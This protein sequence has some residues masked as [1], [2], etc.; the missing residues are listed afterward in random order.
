[1]ELALSGTA[2][3]GLTTNLQFLAAV[4]KNAAFQAGGV[5][6]GFID[7][8]M[9]SLIPPIAPP[10]AEDLALAAVTALMRRQPPPSVGNDARSPWGLGNAWRSNQENW[11]PVTFTVDGQKY[12]VLLQMLAGGYRLRVKDGDEDGD[13]DGGEDGD[14]DFTIEAGLAPDGMLL[15]LID[16][17][18][19]RCHTALWD[20][21]ISLMRDGKCT[22]FRLIEEA[23]DDEEDA[24]GPGAVIAP[25][26]GRIIELLSEDGTAVQAGAPL[27]I[28]E[29]MK[30]EYTLTAPRHGTVDGIRIKAGDQVIDGQLL[31]TV[32]QAD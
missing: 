25:M 26:P 31:L 21:T 17:E 9:T 8:H 24:E 6:T 32:S 16:G 30:M 18:E 22:N 10:S 3:A 14:E 12:H 13:E 20:H 11:D 1:M 28:M 23:G 29:A 19:T 27:I 15:A 2:I 4:L 5:D 7:L